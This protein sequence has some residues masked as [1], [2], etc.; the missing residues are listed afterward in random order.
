MAQLGGFEK[1]VVFF[2]HLLFLR[3]SVPNSLIVR[4][5]GMKTM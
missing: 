1:M 4:I 3:A 5:G 2:L